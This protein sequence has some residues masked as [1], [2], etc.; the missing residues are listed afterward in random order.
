MK[1]LLENMFHTGIAN[2]NN[3]FS[4]QQIYEELVQR[5]QLEELDENNIFKSSTIQN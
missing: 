2:L 1:Y 4:T 5:A 3:K